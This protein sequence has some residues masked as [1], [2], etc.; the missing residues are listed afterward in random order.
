MNP[1]DILLLPGW[2]DSGPGHWQTAWE[3]R[4]GCT[5]VAQH[6][7][8]RPLR[9]DWAALGMNLL[10]AHR[11]LKVMELAGAGAP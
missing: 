1:S 10:K 6:D 8:M 9:G 4:H 11:K 3:Q 5:R 2:Q 7:W